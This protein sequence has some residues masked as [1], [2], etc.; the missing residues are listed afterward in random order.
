MSLS[1]IIS[2]PA[3]SFFLDQ[4]C[5]IYSGCIQRGAEGLIAAVLMTHLNQSQ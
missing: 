3:Q 2:P 4:S 1:F 5:G